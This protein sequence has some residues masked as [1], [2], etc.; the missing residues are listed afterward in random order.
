VRIDRM[1]RRSIRELVTN[2]WRSHKDR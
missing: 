1:N 2:V